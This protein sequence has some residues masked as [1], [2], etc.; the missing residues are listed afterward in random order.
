MM[1]DRTPLFDEDKITS[2]NH[3][4]NHFVRNYSGLVRISSNN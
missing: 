4:S 1:F 2:I 3:L